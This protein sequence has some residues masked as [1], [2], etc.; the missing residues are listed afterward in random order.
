[1]INCC[2]I[3]RLTFF[4]VL[5]QAAMFW[6]S[7]CC[8]NPQTKPRDLRWLYSP[9]CSSA[10]GPCCGADKAFIIASLPYPVYEGRRPPLPKGLWGGPGVDLI[11][12]LSENTSKAS[13]KP[14][15]NRAW[16]EFENVLCADYFFSFSIKKSLVRQRGRTTLSG[17]IWLHTEH[18]GF[19]FSFSF[20][21]WGIFKIYHHSSEHIDQQSRTLKDGEDVSLT[22]LLTSRIVTA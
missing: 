13:V 1:M 19:P 17:T 12:F 11:L 16:P 7:S 8:L 9:E 15:V 14:W 4:Q 10:G 21:L 3:I 20:Q 6:I 18:S 2:F 22:A 5:Q